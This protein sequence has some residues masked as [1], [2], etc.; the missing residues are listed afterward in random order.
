[1]RVMK[2]RIRTKLL[3]LLALATAVGSVPQGRAADSPEAVDKLLDLL[4]K[5]GFVDTQEAKE[6]ESEIHT[7]QVETISGPSSKWVISKALK[8]VDLYGDLRVRYEDRGAQDPGG[9][10]IDLQR[11]RYAARVGLRGD[12]YDHFYYGFRMDTA[13]NPRSPYVTL[14]TSSSG[15]S[16]YQGPFG[17]S[18]GGINIGLVY[19]GWKPTDWLDVTVGKMANPLY[20]TPMVWDTDLAPE[21]AAEKFKYSAGRANLFATFGQFLYADFNPNYA[22][23]GFGINGS[24]GKNTDNIFMFPWQGGLNYQITTNLSAKIAATVYNYIGAHRSTAS[25]FGAYSP[26]FGDPYIGEGAYYLSGG[27]NAQGYSGFGTSSGLPG[28]GSSN[29]PL[30]QVGIDHLS[31]LEIPFEVNYRMERF[32]A[33]FYGDFA[34]NLDGGAR[35]QEAVNAYNAV[36]QA[37]TSGTPLP[38]TVPLKKNQVKAYQ[39]GL[40]LASRDSSGLVYGVTSHRHGWEVRTYWQHVEQYALDPNLLDSDFFE[41]RGNLQGVY[42]ALGYGLTEN[43][44]GIFRYGH[45]WRIDNQ[46]G[47]GGSNQDMPWINPIQ[48]YDV[49]QLDFMFRF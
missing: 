34:Y 3:T 30:N 20:T 27:G 7:N 41:G 45:A 43:L 10:S 36:Q 9:R 35:A 17:K 12:L 33:K 32:D 29:Y 31:V 49:F 25:S 38:H 5:K 48:D 4:V 19:L 42:V 13:A 46:L 2:T 15:S 44:T 8:N 1:M 11:F 23:S 39:L 28:Y 21:G 18:N 40:D 6:L 47:T 37:Q 24:I 14:G 22:S 16:V 26:Y